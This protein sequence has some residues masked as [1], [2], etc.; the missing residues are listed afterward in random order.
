M[1]EEV[2]TAHG[3]EFDAGNRALLCQTA[4]EDLGTAE[5]YLLV[6]TMDGSVAKVMAATKSQ[7]DMD[8]T[9]LRASFSEFEAILTERYG[10]PSY[11]IDQADEDWAYSEIP[12]MFAGALSRQ[13]YT[14]ATGWSMDGVSIMLEGKSPNGI[15][16]EIWL[17]YEHIP[18]GTSRAGTLDPERRSLVG[19]HRQ[20]PQLLVDLG[21]QLLQCLRCGV[22]DNELGIEVFGL[23]KYLVEDTEKLSRQLLDAVGTGPDDNSLSLGTFNLVNKTTKERWENPLATIRSHQTENSKK[24]SGCVEELVDRGLGGHGHGFLHVQRRR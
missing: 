20:H 13:E 8:G 14:L 21:V 22:E 2:R 18:D 7:P 4:P 17:H 10:E 15:S 6:L 1:S 11:R 5:V 12:A 3:C 16:T 19:L 23:G 9:L 24:V